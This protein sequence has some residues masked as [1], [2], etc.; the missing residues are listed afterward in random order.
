MAYKKLTINILAGKYSVIF[1]GIF[2]FLIALLL[3][4]QLDT[5]TLYL[6]DESLLAL[7]TDYM[8]RDGNYLFTHYQNTPDFWNTK[9]HLLI[10]L[11]T[12]SAKIFGLTEWSI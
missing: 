8:L 1:V 11:Q 5:H 4:Y 7:N 3:F 10:L 9:P 12:A 2:F 6:L